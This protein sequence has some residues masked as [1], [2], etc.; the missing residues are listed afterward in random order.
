MKTNKKKNK[1]SKKIELLSEKDF[2][3]LATSTASAKVGI[4]S[5]I[6]DSHYT[7]QGDHP[8]DRIYRD[9]AYI[10]RLQTHIDEVYEALEG[11][12]NLKEDQNWLFDYIYNEEDNIEFEDYLSKFKVQYDEIVK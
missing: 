6:N 9:K 1:P 12:L 8:E 11:D 7:P 4:S 2:A 3:L 5:T 10:Q